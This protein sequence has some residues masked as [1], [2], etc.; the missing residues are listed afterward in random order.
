MPADLGAL[1]CTAKSSTGS[2]LLLKWKE[3]T[4]DLVAYGYAAELYQELD[5]R[6]HRED[7]V[8]AHVPQSTCSQREEPSHRSHLAKKLNFNTN[9]A[10]IHDV[11]ASNDDTSSVSSSEESESDHDIYDDMVV[12]S[13]LVDEAA[14]LCQYYSA[15]SP[16]GFKQ[17]FT[18]ERLATL[19]KSGHQEVEEVPDHFNAN[20][21]MLSSTQL[22]LLI[23]RSLRRN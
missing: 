15:N 2:G 16:L 20:Q 8:G 19:R 13:Y 7:H 22:P 18:Q 12:P 10:A 11:L 5:N 4:H 6:T 17:I 1:T 14:D 21:N 3:I 9:D 23:F